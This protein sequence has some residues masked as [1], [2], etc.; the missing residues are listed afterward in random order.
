MISASREKRVPFWQIFVQT[1]RVHFR[2]LLTNQKIA[3]ALVSIPKDFTWRC[4]RH[5]L[6]RKSRAHSLLG[7]NKKNQYANTLTCLLEPPWEEIWKGTEN[8]FTWK[9]LL[10]LRRTKFQTTNY[11][12]DRGIASGT[13]KYTFN[14]LR[15]WIRTFASGRSKELSPTCENIKR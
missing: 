6:W 7:E 15:T 1:R 2:C 9:C 13:L 8:K 10:L 4:L 12:F 5:I 3:L 14:D 11:K